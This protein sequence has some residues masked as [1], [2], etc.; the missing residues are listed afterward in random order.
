M[1][2][3]DMLNKLFSYTHNTAIAMANT[4]NLI[5]EEH[6]EFLPIKGVLPIVLGLYEFNCVM[7]VCEYRVAVFM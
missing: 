4:C 1:F 5:N 7:L 3:S 6:Q 2:S